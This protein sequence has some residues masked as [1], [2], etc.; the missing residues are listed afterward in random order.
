MP[1]VYRT[2]GP[3]GAG[4]GANLPAEDVDGNFY[5]LD[6]RVADLEDAPAPSF[7]VSVSQAGSV[8]TFTINGVD[9]DIT[10]PSSSAILAADIITVAGT[11]FTPGLPNAQAYHRCTSATDVTVT[12]P[13]NSSV[14]FPIKTELHFRQVGAGQ[15]MLAEGAGVT[16]NGMTGYD[17]TTAA[18]GAVLTVKKV[19]ADEWDV[20][21]QLLPS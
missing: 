10:L 1:I 4:T 9:Y 7:A 6:Q 2:T 11:A 13:P 12:I 21:G 14:A 5:D 18:Q 3:W 8:A 19:A 15:V 16:L 20:F 17:L